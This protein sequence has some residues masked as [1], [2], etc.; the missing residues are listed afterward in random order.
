MST[1]RTKQIKTWSMLIACVGIVAGCKPPPQAAMPPRPP[2]PVTVVS[3]KAQDVPIYLEEIGKT[4]ASEY[5]TIQP[6]ISGQLKEIKFKDGADL[7]KNDLLFVIDPRPFEAAVNQA[8]ANAT[9]QRAALELAKQD[10]ARAE[11]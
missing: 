2:A 1:S 7:K 10:F 9:Q 8:E 6:Q 3:A 11:E 5:V 4:W